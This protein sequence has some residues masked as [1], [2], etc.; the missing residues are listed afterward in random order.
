MTT[1]PTSD[2]PPS[3]PR[4]RGSSIILVLTCLTAVALFATVA[5]SAAV[6]SLRTADRSTDWNQA[7]SAAEAGV[8]DYLARLNKDDGYWTSVDCTN[9]ALK[10]PL[11]GTNTCG[12]SGTTTPGWLPVPGA[13][14]STF[15][16]DVDST[17]TYSTGA[18]KLASTGKVGDT[19]R[20]V[21]VRLRRGGFGE[22]LYY[23]VYETTDPADERV[24]GI[25]NATV[26]NECT[27]YNW[28]SLPASQQRPEGR[29]SGG[30]GYCTTIN[31]VTGDVINGPMHTNDAFQVTGSPRFKGTTTTSN[32]GCRASESGPPPITACYVNGG[33]ASPVFERGLAY[34]AEI[35]LPTSIGDL[36]QYV[37]ASPK[38]P[39]PGCLYTGPTR[40]KFLPTT[41]SATPQMQV[42]S[43]FSTGTLNPG[44]GTTGTGSGALGSSTGA[45]VDVPQERLILVEDVPASRTT[46]TVST[47]KTTGGI[48]DGLP[49]AGTTGTYPDYD[50]N[51]NLAESS[52]RYGT[53]Y[54]QGVL[55]GRTTLAAD[56]N[57][58][59]T[60][61]LTYASGRTGTDVLGLIAKNSVRVYHPMKC[62]ARNSSGV[63]TT[64][65]NLAGT[66]SSGV[67]VNAAILTLQHS[68]SVQQYHEG[69]RLGTLKLYGSFAQRFRG[70]VGTSSGGT[71]VTGYLKDYTYD[72]RLR[73][74]PPPFFLDPVRSGWGQKTFGELTPRY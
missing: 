33:S 21:E 49:L 55:K 71:T 11:N 18:I 73:Y 44:C 56:N 67:E 3:T 23:T 1:Q 26:Q 5:L 37:V 53:V 64:W 14:D 17:S 9:N 20:T 59:V 36:R 54:V 30:Y 7:L 13:P 29:S 57:I 35:E 41:G 6:G 48:G 27:R 66:M 50:V 38:A 8:A 31:F 22:F 61:N 45:T 51:L 34:R 58:I 12:W 28:P 68:F 60:G 69:G 19:T 46:P 32:P 65:A 42:W 47:C 52:C 70:P 74:A 43:K 25:S 39:V 24:Y 16:Y 15:H 63:C 62:T 10:G 72:T 40:I 4:D 2:G